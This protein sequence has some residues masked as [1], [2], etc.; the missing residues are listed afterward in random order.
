M[1]TKCFIII[2]VSFGILIFPNT[3][4]HSQKDTIQSEKEYFSI[5]KYSILQKNTIE[6]KTISYKKTHYIVSIVEPL[7]RHSLSSLDDNIKSQAYQKSNFD[8][9]CYIS[10]STDLIINLN[11]FNATKIFIFDIMGINIHSQSL[12]NKSNCVS[13][14]IDSYVSGT[15]FILLASEDNKKVFLKFV[16]N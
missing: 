7:K 2:I 13:I 16:K 10:S 15:Y 12:K 3:I 14:K 9:Y 4:L 11:G 5:E 6:W 1:K 8:P